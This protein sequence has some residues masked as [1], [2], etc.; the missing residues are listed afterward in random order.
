MNSSTLR[1]KRK[2][3]LEFK[4]MT[5]KEI[6][7][8]R[9]VFG[10]YGI[11]LM[12]IGAI[13]LLPLIMLP[14]YPSEAK[15]FHAFLIPG[16]VSFV[17]GA[18]LF[19]S[20]IFHRAKGKLTTVEDLLLVVGVWILIIFF[21]AL[22]FLFYGYTFTQSI[23]ESTSGYTNAG[24][25]IMDW[26]NSSIET[27]VE[28]ENGTTDVVNHMLFFHRALTQLVGGTGLVLI[29]SSAISERSNLNLYLL[30]GH[31]DK[32]LPNLAKSARLIFSIYL[33]FIVVGSG[34]Y[35]A[36]G[37]TPFDAICHSMAAVATGGFSTKANNINTL[38]YEVSL[39]GGAWRGVMVEIVTELLVILGGINFVIH[40]SLIRRK[41]AVVKHF[42]FFVF[43]GLLI[44]LFPV[45]VVGMT[46]Y[47][48]GDFLKGLRYGTF[49]FFSSLSSAGF[50]AVDSYQG[51]IVGSNY[52]VFPT[53]ALFILGL[54]MCVGMQNGSTSGGIKQNRIAL[55]FMN[56]GWRIRSSFG[57]PDTYRVHLTYKFGQ[58]VRIENDEVVEAETFVLLYLSTLFIGAIILGITCSVVPDMTKIGVDGPEPFTFLDCLFEISSCIGD[59]GLSVGMTNYH[60]IPF[61]LWVE[62]IE[63]LLGRLEIFVFITLGGKVYT[64]LKKRKFIYNRDKETADALDQHLYNQEEVENE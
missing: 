57:K 24:M 48:G 61:I 49:D 29:V 26:S 31:N 3:S 34:L 56:L 11:F 54:L 62:L 22:P 53:Y 51:H 59:N 12:F 4:T 35:I 2:K 36:F 17:I 55:I 8:P 64:Y 20:L 18:A 37:V 52:I 41:F 44:V 40:Y 30:E 45:L 38:V 14:F 7:G 23:F 58:K 9:L 21:S 10:Y 43:F 63:M 25:S 32:L 27:L 42:E 33:G 16:L 15:Y 19:F 5:R 47:Y 28:L 1:T 50:Q 46:Q 39:L 13:V 60:T 6:K